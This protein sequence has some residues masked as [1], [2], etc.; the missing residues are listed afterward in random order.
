LISRGAARV[1]RRAVSPQTAAA[2]IRRWILGLALLLVVGTALTLLLL[3]SHHRGALERYRAELRA[4]GQPQD[5][6]RNRPAAAHQ[7]AERRACAD[8]FVRA[9]AGCAGLPAIAAGRSAVRGAARALAGSCSARSKA[10]P[11]PGPPCSIACA[12][13]PRHWPNCAPPARMPAFDFAP[14]YEDGAH[15]SLSH[16]AGAKR[17]IQMLTADA[18]VQLHDG[19]PEVALADVEAGLNF[20]ARW[21][22]E[23]TLITQLVRIALASILSSATWD[24]LEHYRGW[25]EADLTSL[26]V[27]VGGTR[28]AGGCGHDPF[29]GGGVDGGR[30]AGLRA[31]GR[32]GPSTHGWRSAPR[33]I[34]L[35]NLCASAW[36]IRKAGFKEVMDRYPRWW[37]FKT[38]APPSTRA[39]V[40]AA[41]RGDSGRQ[42]RSPC[43]RSVAGPGAKRLQPHR[44]VTAGT[45]AL[46]DLAGGR[47]LISP[48]CCTNTQPLR[49]SVRS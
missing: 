16:L 33:A 38:V 6:C 7:R 30:P 1:A 17:L 11:M 4:K 25:T 27:G 10:R 26:Q 40:P 8:Q 47:L 19:H 3:S 36:R 15:M 48:V 21:N 20:T 39:G 28:P 24:L 23:P 32:H 37:A 49:R 42:P 45:P 2:M 44:A 41:D 18:L 5:L 12:P 13:I 9:P 35:R 22:R 29:H 31:A 46:A 14:R 43:Q 34:P